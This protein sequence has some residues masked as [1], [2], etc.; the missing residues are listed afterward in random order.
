MEMVNSSLDAPLTMRHCTVAPLSAAV[1]LCMVMLDG[2]GPREVSGDVIRS[3]SLF[4]VCA[5]VL[6]APVKPG[7]AVTIQTSTG[8]PVALQ[9]KVKLSPEQVCPLMRLRVTEEDRKEYT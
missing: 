4:R 2:F 7:S 3:M 1:T 5:K 6:E 9:E 8:V